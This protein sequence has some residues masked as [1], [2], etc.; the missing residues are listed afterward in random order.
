MPRLSASAIAGCQ[1][2]GQKTAPKNK[3]T[4]PQEEGPICLG[5]LWLGELVAG[6]LGK[7]QRPTILIRDHP[8]FRPVL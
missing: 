1:A 6:A 8:A 7:R 5:S 4:A 2:F 3:K